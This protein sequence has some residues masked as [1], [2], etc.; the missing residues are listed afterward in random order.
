[1]DSKADYVQL[2]LASVA[3][4]TNIYIYIYVYKKKLKQTPVPT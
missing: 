1:V 3:R 2:K 4:K